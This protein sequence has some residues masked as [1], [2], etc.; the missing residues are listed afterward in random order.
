V[1]CVSCARV[2]PSNVLIADGGRP[3]LTDFDVSSVDIARDG[4]GTFT[5]S[6]AAAIGT[7]RFWPPEAVPGVTVPSADISAIVR[8]QRW[9]SWSLG[10]IILMVYTG[11]DPQHFPPQTFAADELKRQTSGRVVPRSVA[12]GVEPVD[13]V[14]DALLIADVTRRST[15]ADV[16]RMSLFTGKP[17]AEPLFDSS[18]SLFACCSS[19]FSLALRL[20]RNATRHR[21][22][23]LR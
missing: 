3:L 15:V 5:R 13:A 2:Q 9:D 20:P 7:P 8:K 1:S 6:A 17:L 14:V 22:E 10:C 12:V 21:V 18:T 4:H 16:L 23:W 19:A 11:A